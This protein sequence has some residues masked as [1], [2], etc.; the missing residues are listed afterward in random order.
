MSSST[1]SC[2]MM[3]MMSTILWD[4]IVMHPIQNPSVANVLG[5]VTVV[6][7]IGMVLRT[8]EQ[9]W[10]V[11]YH[12]SVWIESF[13]SV[14]KIVLNDLPSSVTSDDGGI[15]NSDPSSSIAIDRV[16]GYIQ[17][18]DPA[19]RQYLGQ[20]PAMTSEQ[21]H[22]LCVQA[23]TAQLTWSRTTFR[24]RRRVLRTLQEYICTH[25]QDI[26]RVSARDSGK[27]YVDACL[28]EILTTVEKIRCIVQHGELW[29]RSESRPTG[30]M[31]FLKHAQVEYVPLG[32]IAPIAPWN[33][34]YVY[35]FWTILY[36][37][38][39]YVYV[40]PKGIGTKRNS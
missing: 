34:P 35:T 31:L 1:G 39:L 14:P 38:I 24:Q 25:I 5:S 28:G 22:K 11:W 36:L 6:F 12:L 20:V 27:P 15:K 40:Y 4:C 17:C 37:Y 33:Y 7:V 30:P 26:C 19:T 3:M 16:P 18:Y 9:Q 13:E 23:K 10:N 21:V 29:L 2:A 32:I 8:L